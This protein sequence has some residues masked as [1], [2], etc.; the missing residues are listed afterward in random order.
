MKKRIFLASLF[1]LLGFVT[2]KIFFKNLP[3]GPSLG[4]E[5]IFSF[6]LVMMFI[7]MIV[8]FD[9]LFQS[10]KNSNRWKMGRYYRSLC[11]LWFAQAKIKKI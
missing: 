1:L 3:G 7:T 8:D 11:R 6:F 10:V 2:N 4:E 5:V 9:H